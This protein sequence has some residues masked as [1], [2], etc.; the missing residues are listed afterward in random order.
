MSPTASN[1]LIEA[2][3]ARWTAREGGAERA[4]YQ[5]FLTELCTLIGVGHPE[6]AGTKTEFNDYVF[7]RRVKFATPDGQTAGGRIDL[8]KK[9]CFVLEAKQSRQ[10]KDNKKFVSETDLFGEKGNARLGRRTADRGWDVLMLNARRQAEDYAKALPPEHGWPPFLLVCDVG[11]CIEVFAD[12]TGQGKNYAQFPDRTGFRIYLEDL[13]D[14]EVRERLAHIWTDPHALDPTRKAA[15][16]TREIAERLAEV[17]KSLE[18]RKYPAED[19]A[20]FLMRCLFTMFAEDVKLLPENSFTGL[21]AECEK[22]P[23]A[24]LPI[25]G[26][27]WKAM[28]KGGFSTSIH[29]DVKI[30]N[31]NLFANAKVI[32]LD[33]EE[34]GELKAAAS[35]DWREVEPAIFGA[36]LEQALDPKER[37]RLGAHYTPRAYVERLVVATIMEPLRADWSQVLATAER[38]KSEGDN[39]APPRS[40]ANSTKRCAKPAYST[41]RAAPATS[42]TCRSN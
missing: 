34:I 7:E 40:C 35:K 39:A 6:P 11:H 27:L 31:G 10:K 8:Y 30:F 33:R 22:N 13:H 28:D 38:L 21:L 16:V 2:F 14:A 5:M 3:I 12:F 1:K 23:K 42:F 41:P 18:R 26:E 19:V 24:L 17:T 37:Q 20:L 15:K 4:N 36:L 25:L 29:N 32:P 9:S